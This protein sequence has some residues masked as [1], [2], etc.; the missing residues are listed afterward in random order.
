MK[1]EWSILC[2][3]ECELS[4]EEQNSLYIAI[5]NGTLG[6]LQWRCPGRRSPSPLNKN[7]EQKPEKNIQ[8][9]PQTKNDFDF[10]DDVILPTMRVRSHNTAKSSNVKKKANFAGVLESLKKQ[11]QNQ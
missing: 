4:P 8:K 6:E 1:E 10:M 7:K 3:P 5:D 9:E 11:M 2:T